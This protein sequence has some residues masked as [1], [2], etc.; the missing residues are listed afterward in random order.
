[1]TAPT[2]NPMPTGTD[3]GRDAHYWAPPRIEPYVRLAR[4]RLPPRMF[5]GCLAA[6]RTR[7]GTPDLKEAKALLDELS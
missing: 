6:F 3:C 2:P 5:D 4:I 1:M 7:F